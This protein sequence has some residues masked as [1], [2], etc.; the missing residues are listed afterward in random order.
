MGQ[1]RLIERIHHRPVL[2]LKRQVRAA[3]QV[4][5]RGDAVGGGD[6]QLVRPEVVLGRTAH[7]HVRCVE[8]G[9]VEPA[10]G[11]EVAHDELDVVDQP[12]SV[13]FLRFHAVLLS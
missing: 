7:G 3:G 9:R 6:K 12:A 13:D 1:G 10:A 2:R 11:G 4:P 5:L 8:H